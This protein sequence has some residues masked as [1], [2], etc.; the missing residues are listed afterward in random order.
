LGKEGTS[1]ERADA[2]TE[3]AK[4]KADGQSKAADHTHSIVCCSFGGIIF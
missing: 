3:G 2:C 1:Y 4:P